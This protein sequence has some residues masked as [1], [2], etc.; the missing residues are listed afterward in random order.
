MRQGRFLALGGPRAHRGQDELVTIPTPAVGAGFSFT[1]DP[2][3]ETVVRVL[4]FTLTASAQVAN[5]MVTFKVVRREIVLWQSFYEPTVTAGLSQVFSL[6][7]G[8][9]PNIGSSKNGVTV[10]VMPELLLK[11]ADL[12]EVTAANLQT[13]DAFSAIRAVKEHFEFGED[14][15]QAEQH[16]L[17]ERIE[18]LE[19]RL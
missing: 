11:P 8:G 18:L 19:R 12:V 3:W 2:R 15:D 1:I 6:Y 17:H 5:R 16:E 14:Y 9:A 4:K 10:A 7:A 13:E